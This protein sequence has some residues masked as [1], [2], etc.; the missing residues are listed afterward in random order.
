VVEFRVLGPVEVL[1]DG[2]PI[3]LGGPKQATIVALLAVEAPRV[4]SSD[5]LIGAVWGD[6]ATTRTNQHL[7]TLVSNLRRALR[8]RT[9]RTLLVSRK[10]GYVL[11][12]TPEEE[13]DLHRFRSLV[14]QARDL[15]ARGDDGGALATF[16]LAE[17]CWRGDLAQDLA[18][19][20]V[21]DLLAGSPHH[22]VRLSA[23]EDRV[24]AQ[25]RLGQHGQLVG[26]LEAMIAEA[27]ARERRWQQLM[28]ALYRAARQKEALDA[29]AR[30]RSHLRDELGLE[31]GPELRALEQ[32]ILAHDP[33]LDLAGA[34]AV[35]APPVASAAPVVASA[36]PVVAS[37]APEVPIAPA[38]APA[39]A[40]TA[41]SGRGE[42]GSHRPTG[43]WTALQGDAGL[44]VVEASGGSV[45][46]RG[47]GRGALRNVGRAR[48][49]DV[50]EEVVASADGTVVA[51]LVDGRLA[52]AAV[53]P[54]GRLRWSGRRDELPVG[55]ELLGVTESGEPV[56]APGATAV[57][58]FGDTEVELRDGAFVGA[59]EPLTGL[60]GPWISLDAATT[61]RASLLAAATGSTV[62]LVQAAGRRVEHRTVDVGGPASRVV[63]ARPTDRRGTPELVCVESAG[64]VR[65]WSWT[66]VKT[67]L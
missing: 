54:G 30:A 16:R 53:L 60:P 67:P 10:P 52:R 45:H 65:W 61:A 57:A 29:F 28:L 56:T 47:L 66:S 50:V 38:E 22:E 42:L 51:A 39:A 58:R 49:G 26:E 46:V 27:P 36:A 8:A 35:A 12:V 37:A 31:P 55:D 33:A 15:A 62:H 32:R 21:A 3:D 59:P 64:T 13:V 48:I 9:D 63:V 19:A 24:D 1:V 7:Q 41:E 14:Q 18:F 2:E 34:G 6:D 4:V 43:P 11:D 44:L 23:Y 5:T 25:L 17:A 20:P 40:P